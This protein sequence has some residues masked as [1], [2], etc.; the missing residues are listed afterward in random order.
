VDALDI[1]NYLNKQELLVETIAVLKKDFRTVGE[2]INIDLADRISFEELK[3]IVL[4]VVENLYFKSQ[5]NFMT[6]VYRVDIP[7]KMFQEIFKKNSF[8][9][10]EE[11]TEKIIKRELQKV[12]IKHLYKNND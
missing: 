12:I 5:Q 4:P 11:L 6:L 8:N 10:I 7:E 9:P 2:E 1:S 3:K